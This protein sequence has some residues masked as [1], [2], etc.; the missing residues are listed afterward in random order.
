MPTKDMAG[1]DLVVREK[2]DKIWQF[3]LENAGAKPRRR[4]DDAEEAQLGRFLDIG[5]IGEGT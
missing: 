5:D 3:R 4:S 2:C 1:S